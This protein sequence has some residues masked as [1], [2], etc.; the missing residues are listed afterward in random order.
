MHKR[1]GHQAKTHNSFIDRGV[2]LMRTVVARAPST[3][4][5]A[6]AEYVFE[7]MTTY[8]SS[9]FSCA[10]IG[11]PI[12]VP[13][14]CAR[15]AGD[16]IEPL[17]HEQVVALRETYFVSAERLGA[18]RITRHDR[19]ALVAMGL[20]VSRLPEPARDMVEWMLDN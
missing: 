14:I 1:A 2:A 18:E 15:R 13:Q 4:F 11:D 5:G 19:E 16:V 12:E 3:T 10:S 9:R 17:T 20:D 8:K 7:F 6:S